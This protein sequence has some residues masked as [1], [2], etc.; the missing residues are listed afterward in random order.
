MRLGDF[1]FSRIQLIG[2]VV[3]IVGLAVGIYLVQKTQIFKPRA[4]G[5]IIQAFD[6]TDT[7]GKKLDCNGST[8]PPTCTT[9]TLDVNIKLAP[10]GLEEL[11][12]P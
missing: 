8:D 4:A 7:N 10:G 11:T 5:S 1:T 12:K 6:I 2:V 3:L 9:S